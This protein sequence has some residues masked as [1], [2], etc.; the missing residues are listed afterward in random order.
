[1]KK[2]TRLTLL[3]L[4]LVLAAEHL[5]IDQRIQEWRERVVV[6]ANIISTVG[7]GGFPAVDGGV[8][9]WMLVN[10]VEGFV[11]FGINSLAN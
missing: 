6:E 11:S 5:I 10:R 4:I 9:K 2:L 7:G 3:V 1:M 8:V